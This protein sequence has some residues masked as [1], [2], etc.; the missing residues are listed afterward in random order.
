LLKSEPQRGHRHSYDSKALKN[1]ILAEKKN[2]NMATPIKNYNTLYGHIIVPC[3][4]SAV[5][6]VRNF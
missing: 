4:K 2:G 1:M 5:S 6:P 3:Y